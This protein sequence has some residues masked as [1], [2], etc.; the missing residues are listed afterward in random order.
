M[1]PGIEAMVPGIISNL[2]TAGEID[3]A[4]ISTCTV[5]GYC[6]LRPT[7]PAKTGGYKD[8]AGELI[9]DGCSG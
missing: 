2:Q 5:S 6:F 7:A 4:K 1:V 9:A 3:L 8:A